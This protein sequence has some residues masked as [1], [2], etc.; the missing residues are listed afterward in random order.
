MVS[1]LHRGKGLTPVMVR[2]KE[3]HYSLK[4]TTPFM[5]DTEGHRIFNLS[6]K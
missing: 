5:W 2:L 3:I 6:A 4:H 1:E